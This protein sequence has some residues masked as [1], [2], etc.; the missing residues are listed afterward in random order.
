MTRLRGD[1]QTDLQPPDTLAACAEAL[2]GLGW[3]IETVDAQR[4][5]SFTGPDSTADGARIDVLLRRAEQGTEVRIIGSDTD[6]NPLEARELVETLNGARDAIRAAVEDSRPTGAASRF[7]NIPLF[8]QRERSVQIVT[9]LVVPAVFGAVAGIVLG[10]SAGLYWAIQVVALIGAV[11][12]GPEHT[13]GPE[14]V[15]PGLV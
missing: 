7:A 12:A 8:R 3:K 15:R 1:F 10:I 13:S 9:A 5:V 6:E 11:L 2:D 14:G 4:I